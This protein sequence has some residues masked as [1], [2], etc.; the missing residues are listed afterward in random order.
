MCPFHFG[1]PPSFV[2][3]RGRLNQ[4]VQLV[5]HWDR[6]IGAYSTPGLSMRFRDCFHFARSLPDV[7]S[8][9][10]I[11]DRSTRGPTAINDS[12]PKSPFLAHAG[13]YGPSV[14]LGVCARCAAPRA[15]RKALR[16]RRRP[17]VFP[18]FSRQC[19]Q[20]LQLNSDH[21][22]ET[23]IFCSLVSSAHVCEETERLARAG[24]ILGSKGEPA[25]SLIS[26]R[27]VRQ[28]HA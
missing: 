4:L 16:V 6:A 7:S 26:R 23:I 27:C 14:Q 25:L 19:L 2:G 28:A 9:L 1:I 17:A 24:V 20:F 10:A 21:T 18:P 5:T 11:I 8:R 3:M 15:S 13:R 12:P 22:L